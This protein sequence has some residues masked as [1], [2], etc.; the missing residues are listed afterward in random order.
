MKIVFYIF[1]F[2]TLN[3]FAQQEDLTKIDGNK[4]V[5]ILG[6]KVNPYGSFRFRA[7]TSEHDGFE[8]GDFLS[9]VGLEGKTNLDKKNKY[10]AI[11]KIELG[12]SLINRDDHIHISLDPGRSVTASVNSAVYSRIAYGGISTPYGNFIYGKNGVSITKL[13]QL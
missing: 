3:L 9:R 8:I 6:A 10:F 2:S 11:T 1:V 12:L 5:E 7:G 4:S 13:L